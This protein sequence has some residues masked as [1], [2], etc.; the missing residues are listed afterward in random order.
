MGKEYEKGKQ[1][2][3]QNTT[4]S[5]QTW[6]R[7]TSQSNMNTPRLG[8]K[9]CPLCYDRSIPANLNAHVNE[10]QTCADVHLQ[11]AMLRYDNAMCAVGQEK[12]QS[13]CCTKQVERNASSVLGVVAGVVVAGLFLKRIFAIRK[14]R[15]VEEMKGLENRIE[16]PRT[17]SLSTRTRSSQSDGERNGTADME[18]SWYVKM[19]EMKAK[20]TRSPRHPSRVRDRPG[21]GYVTN[22][23]RLDQNRPSSKSRARSRSR[24]ASRSRPEST[25]SIKSKP[26]INSRARSRSRSRNMPETSLST[27]DNRLRSLSRPRE[28][29]E[30]TT[31]TSSGRSR[32]TENSRSNRTA[33]RS[34]ARS[35]SRPRTKLDS[36]HSSRDRSMSRSRAKSRSRARSRSRAAEKGRRSEFQEVS[37]YNNDGPVLPSQ[38]V[39]RI[40]RLHISLMEYYYE[41][42]TK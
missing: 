11:L 39:W 1:K 32:P 34:R 23:N 36:T 9:G 29:S 24:S 37:L 38:V 17:E 5:R 28:T 22:S 15:R 10:S 8:S 41:T 19:E 40:P 31:H 35:R 16:L 42:C 12:Y 30:N 18:T 26:M 21:V 25:R 14:R 4:Y 6:S 7:E 2:E 3:K 33:S 20:A 27:R 13:L